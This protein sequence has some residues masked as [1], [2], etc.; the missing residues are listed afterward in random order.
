MTVSAPYSSHLCTAPCYLYLSIS[1]RR[2][3]YQFLKIKFVQKCHHTFTSVEC[4]CARKVVV[5]HHN[6]QMSKSFWMPSF[7]ERNLFYLSEYLFF[8]LY[9]MI[10]IFFFFCRFALLGNGA[11]CS[12]AFY[13][14]K[15]IENS[16]KDEDV[17]VWCRWC[18]EGESWQRDFD[19]LSFSDS[20]KWEEDAGG[21]NLSV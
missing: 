16:Q 21:W 11:A 9:L 1:P 10:W 4:I 15:K 14:E 6:P 5:I 13:S 20:D 19:F 8:S 2:M 7:L 18:D 12:V 3:R 17:V